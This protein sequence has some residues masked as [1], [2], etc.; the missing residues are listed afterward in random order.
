MSDQFRNRSQSRASSDTEHDK[1]EFQQ[2]YVNIT[3]RRKNSKGKGTNQNNNLYD[4]T[5]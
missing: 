4:S 5:D 1:R 2:P 3:T